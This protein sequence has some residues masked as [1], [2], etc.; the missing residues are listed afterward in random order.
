[1]I[2]QFVDNSNTEVWIDISEIKR[3]EKCKDWETDDTYICLY[4]TDTF[5]SIMP[6]HYFESFMELWTEC[7]SHS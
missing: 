4:F 6:E 7:K 1:M 2:F 3:V 5:F